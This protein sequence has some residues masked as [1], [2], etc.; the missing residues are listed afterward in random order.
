M[1]TSAHP[2][3]LTPKRSSPSPGSISLLEEFALRCLCLYRTQT[4][5]VRPVMQ[6][7]AEAARDNLEATEGKE[8]G[9]EDRGR[10]EK[11]R[12]GKK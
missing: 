6:L 5:S 11:E 3:A 4:L 8:K 9:Q 1:T 7:T 10:L 2:A 12:G